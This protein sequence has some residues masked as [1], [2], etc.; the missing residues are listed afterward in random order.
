[1]ARKVNT[2]KAL[3]VTL[4]ILAIM[5]SATNHVY[6]KDVML[7]SKIQNV[8]VNLDKN[9][10]EYVRVIIEK[11]KEL[12]GVAYTI[13]VPVMAFGD[14]VNQARNLIEGD[15]LKAICSAGEYKG[16]TSYTLLAIIE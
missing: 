10:N 13:G 4:V 8:T 6:A 7:E 5:L 15:S 14:I 9:G 12:N 1:M 3:L 11:Q 2:M 16:R